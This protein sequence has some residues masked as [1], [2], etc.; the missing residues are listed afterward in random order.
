MTMPP[1]NRGERG[2]VAVVVAVVAVVLFG[3][4]AYAIDTGNLW[5]TRRNMVTASDAGALAAA[6]QYARGLDGCA[7][8]VGVLTAN[9]SDA[10]LDSCTPSGTGTHGY[11]TVSG[12]TT[13]PLSFAGIFGMSNKQVDA[14]TTAEWGTPSSAT[15]LRPI[16]LCLTATPELEDWLNLPA[17]PSGPTTSPV[18]ITLSNAQPDACVDSDG[19]ASGNWGLAFGDGNTSNSSTKDW[20]ENGYPNEVGIGE[21]IDANTG[22]FSGSVADALETLQDDGTWF[23]LPVFDRV[24]GEGGT[25]ATYH[26][27]AFVRVQLVDYDVTGTQASR[28][29]TVNFDRGLIQGKCCG[30]GPD[31]GTHVVRICD[32][33]AV[34]PDTSS[35]AC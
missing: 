27:V 35:N 30:F 31:T 6:G 18:K 34:N 4:A 8:A 15:G 26:V 32:V 5:Q 11:V 10:A 2:A 13:V 1:S 25:K 22:A 29:I 9:R 16:A 33:D 28:F 12:H 23:A 19:N 7:A 17:G 21:N 20:L 24:V 14:A 3:A